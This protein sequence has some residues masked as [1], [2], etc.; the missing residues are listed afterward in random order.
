MR[1]IN[2]L[3]LRAL[4]VGLGLTVM[5]GVATASPVAYQSLGAG[6]NS[7]A[8]MGAPGGAE[9]VVV[10]DDAGWRALVGRH[11][12]VGQLTKPNFQS[13]MAIG[14]FMGPRP[15]GG[16]SI[17]VTSIDQSAGEL[18]VTVQARS[19][20]P[21]MI[22][23]Q[24][25]TSPWQVV[26][27]A[28]SSLPVRFT[29]SSGAR[30]MP[31][32]WSTIERGT[33][34]GDH[35]AAPAQLVFTDAAAFGRFWSGHSTRAAPTVDF[36]RET[37]V[38]VLRGEKTSGGYGVEV[39]GMSR[40]GATRVNVTVDY[41]DPQP[42]GFTTTVMTYPFHIVKVEGTGLRFNFQINTPNA[43]VAFSDLT[44]N[45]VNASARTHERL[46]VDASGRAILEV[47]DTA[48][49]VTKRHEETL[50]AR[51]M[52][53]LN[54]LLA[55]ADIYNATATP[56]R[57]VPGASSYDLTVSDNASG[58]SNSLRWQGPGPLNPPV[59]A[60][61]DH[62]ENLINK[63]A[64]VATAPG[65]FDRLRFVEMLPTPNG[66]SRLEVVVNADGTATRTFSAPTIRTVPVTGRISTA[67]LAELGRRFAATDFFNQNLPA[68]LVSPGTPMTTLFAEQG[69][70]SH[71]LTRVSSTA[72]GGPKGAELTALEAFLR[73]ITIQQGA[74]GFDT[75]TYSTALNGFILASESISVSKS[76][77]ATWTERRNG[78]VTSTRTGALDPAEVRRLD[79]LFQATDFLNQTFPPYSPSAG[80]RTQSIEATVAGNTAALT[81]RSG[82]YSG[83][84]AAEIGALETFLD[85]L[86]KRGPASGGARF[87]DIQYTMTDS[88]TGL[89][90]ELFLRGDELQYRLAK[91]NTSLDKQQTTLPAGEAQRLQDL[92]AA[93]DF[94]QQPAVLPILTRMMITTSRQI[95]ATEGGR[96]HSV[97]TA[98][99]ASEPAGLKALRA[100]LEALL[101][102][103]QPGAIEHEGRVNVIETFPEQ[104]VINDGAVEFRVTGPKTNEVKRL[105]YARVRG[106]VNTRGEL[107]V[108]ELLTPS[109]ITLE[110][111]VAV[112]RGATVLDANSRLW[113]ITGSLES[114]LRAM[115]GL[116]VKVT[117]TPSGAGALEVT[118]IH[119]PKPATVT[120]T[121]LEDAGKL[122]IA[123]GRR[124][125]IVEGDLNET[126]RRSLGLEI[127]VAGYAY[128]GDKLNVRSVFVTAQR[129]GWAYPG[130]YV[131]RGARLE[132]LREVGSLSLLRART[133]SG[134]TVVLIASTRNFKATAIASTGITGALRGR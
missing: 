72:F 21:G 121:V 106:T 12:A 44:M 120:G 132:V 27:L 119:M 23:T 129:S 18:V 15:T 13:E 42:G 76:G 96:K 30:P 62:L 7:G 14:V 66:N 92:Y 20:A 125:M 73:N 58:R 31:V 54:R 67:D 19:P 9:N 1:M 16:Y 45:R 128:P 97:A 105:R 17:A 22:V 87:D 130:I 46:T 93:A 26:T 131:P 114:D 37:V 133:R 60:L 53:E 29:T 5:A 36:Q 32:S 56:S 95:T 52:S 110:G 38:A 127:T 25:F 34:S 47:L 39:S 112:R 117:G 71:F 103:Y 115:N 107:V 70:S 4:A 65:A 79:A 8:P 111:T 94:F 77:D 2:T 28:K 50:V 11:G 3:G 35:R 41:S 108:T 80:D 86:L 55:S 124:R 122:V 48:G 6:A 59:K 123:A 134:R 99:V 64:R 49:A 98:P 82:Q 24:A 126:V 74:S 90:R 10:K 116:P 113:P 100:A 91:G 69:A 57:P 104:V 102:Q 33:Q 40:S 78:Q 63:F 118:A 101:G 109:P 43:P 83:P 75:I 85:A 68:P 89:T 81:H 61:A 84:K 51:H 88:M